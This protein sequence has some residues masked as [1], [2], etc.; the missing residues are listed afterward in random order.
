MATRVLGRP[1]R[2]GIR[3]GGVVVLSI[4][5]I[6]AMIVGAVVLLN[7]RDGAEREPARSQA[8]A[9][10]F[11]VLP[12]DN[13]ILALNDEPDDPVRIG[14]NGIVTLLD[15]TSRT[16]HVEIKT[17]YTPWVALRR[18]TGQ[19]LV[20]E[21]FGP[22]ASAT[23]PRLRVFEL[24][25]LDITPR[26]IPL[27]GRATSTTYYPGM[28]LSS[29]ERVLYYLRYASIC[30]SG[31]A[32]EA[33]DQFSIVALDLGAGVEVG[34]AQLPIGCSFPEIVALKGDALAICRRGEVTV[35]RVSRDGA[36]HEVG[37]FPQRTQQDTG[38]PIGPVMAGIA[39]DG[40]AYVV[41]ADGKVYSAGNPDSIGDLL[42][43]D[44]ERIG[45]NAFTLL[46]DNTAILAYGVVEAAHAPF[47]EAYVG[48]LF[49]NRADPINSTT[50]VA[51]PFAASSVAALDA[52]TLVLR[53]SSDSRLATFHTADR[54]TEQGDTLEG[55]QW[56]VR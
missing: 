3:R 25:N 18:T 34:S 36:V 2:G 56:L 45:Y 47:A 7:T 44:N 39:S 19:L 46:D 21:L 24:N 40:L 28:A 51:F 43:G 48:A 32:A 10:A 37:V 55:T 54:T 14:A 26:V 33:C 22:E 1:G 42:P 15:A 8:P 41:Y 16:S 49:M 29:D 35:H 27:P 4:A 30:P 52:N 38:N 31:G 23:E 9:A 13:V 5:A 6:A 50:H 20:A 53:G 11:N 12:A 17:G